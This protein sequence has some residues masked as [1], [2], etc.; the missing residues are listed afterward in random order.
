M[1]VSDTT[2]YLKATSI[3]IKFILEIFEY[4]QKWFALILISGQ[5]LTKLEPVAVSS[6]ATREKA[7]GVTPPGAITE[8]LLFIS[9]TN[10][11]YSLKYLKIEIKHLVNLHF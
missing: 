8:L 7:V 9:W 4:E 3:Q 10:F 5:Y 6:P 1:K 11:P 2:Q